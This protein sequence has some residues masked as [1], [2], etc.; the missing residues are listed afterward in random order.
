M[1]IARRDIDDLCVLDFLGNVLQVDRI[2][3]A[4]IAPDVDLAVGVDAD[5]VGRAGRDIGDLVLHAV[6]DLHHVHAG[7]DVQLGII[8]IGQV[9]RVELRA[10]HD[11]QEDQQEHDQAGHAEPVM[12]EILE[13]QTA[14]ALQLFLGHEV[15]DLVAVAEQTGKEG[16]FFL[17]SHIRDPPL[18]IDAHTRVDDAVAEVGDQLAD[19]RNEHVEHLDR[20]RELKVVV[21]E[22]LIVELAHAVEREHLLNDQR[23]GEDADEPADQNGDDREQR[24]APPSEPTV[25]TSTGSVM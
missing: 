14:R 7:R 12:Q 5:A 8:L 13:D 19:E 11:Q 10:D 21:H 16:R 24:V 9:E 22:A 15:G 4:G 2:G 6:R 3:D 1:V 25:M 17:F 23:T 18:L 20:Q